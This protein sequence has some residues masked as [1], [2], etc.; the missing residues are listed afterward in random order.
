MDFTEK[1]LKKINSYNGIIVGVKVE[2]VELPNGRKALRE[3]VEHPGGVA[4]LPV[5]SDG[6]AYCVRQYRYTFSSHLI[7]VPAGKIEPGE[8]TLECA[9]RELSEETGITAGK[10]IYLGELYPSPGFCKEVLHAYLATD[11]TMGES[12]P[13]TNEF[14]DVVRIHMDDLVS[15]VMGGEIKDAKTIIAV[16]K[17]KYA[18]GNEDGKESIDR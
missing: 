12:H 7:E 10:Y 2:Q 16:L 3:I 9:V 15:M 5:D 14:L 4:I 8:T 1:I 17:A 11:L 18:W 6:Y 13:D